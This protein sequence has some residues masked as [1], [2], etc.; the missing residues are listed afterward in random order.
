MDIIGSDG[1]GRI[2]NHI[3]VVLPGQS[4]DRLHG[5]ALPKEVD[6]YDGSGFG[7]DGRPNL[8][9]IQGKGDRVHIHQNRCQTQQGNGLGRCD[10]GERSR[11]QFVPGLQIQ[12]HHG[13]LQGIGPVGTGDDLHPAQ[14]GPQFL[15][16]GLDR[17]TVDEGGLIHDLGEALVDLVLDGQVLGT[18]VHHGAHAHQKG[19]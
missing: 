11:D 18:E 8:L 19:G 10:V 2:L 14:I 17:R 13:N 16:K 15:R 6:R 9:R 4:Q 1:L 3:E 5:R 12:G 7:A